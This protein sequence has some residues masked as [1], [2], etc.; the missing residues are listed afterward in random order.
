MRSRLL[1][2][3]LAASCAL[4]ACGGARKQA[5]PVPPDLSPT[6]V[7]R[8]TEPP[9]DQLPA[10]MVDLS[11]RST[12]RALSAAEVDGAV[13]ATCSKGTSASLK[14]F[15]RERLPDVD[16]GAAAL[17]G[18][19]VALIDA[20]C[21]LAPGQVLELESAA[22][23]ELAL[24]GM[25]ASARGT[26]RER[27]LNDQACGV[28]LSSDQSVAR[29]VD[30]SPAWRPA[31]TSSAGERSRSAS[32]PWSRHARCSS[33]T[34]ADRS[35]GCADSEPCARPSPRSAAP[36]LGTVGGAMATVQRTLQRSEL[37]ILAILGVPTFALAL[38]ITT[39]STY[40]PVLA[41]DFS[42]SSIV[43]GLL[44]GGEGL[45]AL[46]LPLVV[47]SWSDRLRTP[48]G[49]RLPFILAAT[50]AL[51]VALAVLGFVDSIARAARRRRG[52]LRRL[53]RRLRA[54]PRPLSGPRRRRDRRA[55]AEQPG[56]LP[57][58]RHLPGAGRRRSAHLDLRPAALR[59]RARSSSG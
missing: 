45:I 15:I 33:A 51:V 36:L 57:R 23:V 21:P 11:R 10:L 55:R 48:L 40:L 8:L 44:I 50:S 26:I 34:C 41:E 2:L 29:I 22:V 18:R 4:V 17:F 12:T 58:P 39:V 53:L 52:L 27:E 35:A 1:P 43:I 19:V 3:L 20:Q 46:W 9:S 54:I 31:T 38:A 28:M 37:R 56:D 47:G 30:G 49:S 14:A 5:E 13:Q 59:G 25:R 24:N 6:P 32:R 7:R 42:D 16:V